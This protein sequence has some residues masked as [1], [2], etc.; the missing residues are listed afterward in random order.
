MPEAERLARA[1]ANYKASRV[2][3]DAAIKAASAG[4]MTL[5]AIAEIAGL[6][7]QRVAQIIDNA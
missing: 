4:G 2:E 6:S 7:F 1:V 5:R 3:R